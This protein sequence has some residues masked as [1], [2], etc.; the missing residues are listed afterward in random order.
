MAHCWRWA[1]QRS[2]EGKRESTKNITITGYI[3]GEEL[4]RIYAGADLFVFPSF[5]ETFGNVVLEAMS[6]G[7]PAVVAKCRRG[8]GVCNK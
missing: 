6:S 7:I 1:K 5:T 4:A 3:K 2:L 8:K